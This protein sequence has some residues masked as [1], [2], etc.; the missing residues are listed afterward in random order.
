MTSPPN[1]RNI[2]PSDGL[3]I[4]SEMQA[5]A[6]KQHVKVALCGGVVMQLFGS[7][8]QTSDVD[9]VA[10]FP[11]DSSTDVVGTL[12]FGGVKYLHR[13]VNVDWIVR[14][15][16]QDFIYQAALADRDK[17]DGFW[18]IDPEWMTIIKL[19]ARRTKDE[20]DLLYLLRTPNLVDRGIVVT[21]LRSVFGRTA[22]AVV[23]EMENRFLEAD[24][25]RARDERHNV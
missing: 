4:A 23:D 10:D 21:R 2:S 13:G 25:M 9:F 5:V 3:T 20:F 24:L 12:S 15:D 6:E 11:L 14:R 1:K 16:E 22:F 7:D 18:T 17:C 8:R 19:L